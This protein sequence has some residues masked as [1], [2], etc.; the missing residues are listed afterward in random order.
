MLNEKDLIAEIKSGSEHSYNL[1]YRMWVSRLY[2]FIFHYVK[3]ASVTDDIVQETFLRIWMNRNTLNPEYSFKSYL[4]TI[5]YRLVLKELRRQLNNPL[6]EEYIEYQQNWITSANE[7]GQ[8][9][10]LEQFN[11]ALFKA[12][13]K[14]PPRQR[15]IF[16]LHKEQH[17]PVNEIAVRLSITEQVVRNQLSAALKTIRNELKYYSYLLLAFLV[18]F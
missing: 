1:L 7:T 3:S 6:M 12:K 14:L 2:R 11:E 10:E 18:N 16:E 9:V 13:Q 5:S 15:E 4:F 17:L 8:K